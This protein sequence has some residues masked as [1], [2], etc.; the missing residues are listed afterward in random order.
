MIGESPASLQQPGNRIPR[1]IRSF[2]EEPVTPRPL[3]WFR[4]GLSAILLVQAFSLIGHLDELYGRHGV[5]A[6]S[7]NSDI[8]P[9]GVPNLS[10]ADRGMGFMGLPGAFGIHLTF[11]IYVAGLIGLF[12][13]YRTRVAAILSWLAHTTLMISSDMSIYGVDY[14]AQIGLFYCLWFPV[15]GALSLDTAKERMKSLPTFEAWLGLR[16]LQLHIC[17]A[18]VA[19]G[20]EKSLGEQWWNGEAV[21]IAVMSTPDG[22]IDCSFLATVPWLARILCWMTLL[23]EA[24]VV[25]FIW[26][27]RGRLLWLVGIV[28]LHLGIAVVMNLWTFSVTMI[29]FDVAAFGSSLRIWPLAAEKHHRES[30]VDSRTSSFSVSVQH[31][32]VNHVTSLS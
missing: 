17:I 8:L 2:W 22:L 15:G 18:Y 32:G 21:W 31:T 30:G 3:A 24:G 5:V 4:I 13:G 27:P 1:T 19:T 12:F 7:V 11:A 23:L 26:H 28:G 20:I 16:I 6:W 25:L 14:F 29:V 10:W 9:P